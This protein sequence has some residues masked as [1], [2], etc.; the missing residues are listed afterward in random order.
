VAHSNKETIQIRDRSVLD[1][2]KTLHFRDLYIDGCCRAS[3]EQRRDGSIKF[4]FHPVGAC[5]YQEA[6]VWLI[7]LLEL[8]M[9]IEDL[10]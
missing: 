4:R 7:G 10:Q 1:G 2:R 6:Q 5:D 9:H 3:L 8:S